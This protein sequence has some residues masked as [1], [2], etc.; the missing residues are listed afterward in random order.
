MKSVSASSANVGAV[1]AA[2]RSEIIGASSGSSV[3]MT[4][5]MSVS[6]APDGSFAVIDTVRYHRRRPQFS[7]SKRSLQAQLD[8]CSI[9]RC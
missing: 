4:V 7:K 9:A 1:F 5:T 3:T 6:V 8:T 2:G